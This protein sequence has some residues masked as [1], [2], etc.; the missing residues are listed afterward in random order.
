MNKNI[1]F[2][3]LICMSF[4]V[5]TVHAQK[6]LYF[7]AVE[8]SVVDIFVFEEIL[9]E[10]YQ[11]IGIKV[12]RR[13]YPMERALTSSNTGKTDGE[14]SRVEG[15]SD[16]Y[17]NLLIIP[18][19]VLNTE[20]VAFSVKDISV[21]KGWESLTQHSVVIQM[22]MKI[23]EINAKKFNWKYSAMIRT[24]QLFMTLIKGRYDVAVTELFKGYASL[25]KLKANSEGK[26]YQSIKLLKPP[27][28]EIK[29]YHYL[30]KSNKDLIPKITASLME[31]EKEGLIKMRKEQYSW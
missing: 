30:H 19:A 25:N 1:A 21:A 18:V 16:K 14:M 5:N 10:G 6:V 8:A 4:F 27:L 3:G 12:K 13:F 22:G 26:E 15:I 20:I 9:T 11:R 29:L 23:V 31:M 7:S 24:D 2:I 17:P 28:L